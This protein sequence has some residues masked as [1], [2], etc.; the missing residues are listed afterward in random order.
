MSDNE[1]LKALLAWQPSMNLVALLDQLYF[2]DVHGV[3]VLSRDSCLAQL[4]LVAVTERL[5]DEQAFHAA[6]LRGALLNLDDKTFLATFASP[7][8]ASNVVQQVTPE[9]RMGAR[10]QAARKLFGEHIYHA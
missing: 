4:L 6:A 9:E 8:L 3:P 7:R 2:N 1:K 5:F 10:L